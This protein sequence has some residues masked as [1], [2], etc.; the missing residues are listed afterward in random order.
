MNIELF[1]GR[2]H[3]LI[4]HLPIGFFLLAIIFEVIGIVRKDRD[5]WH[6]PVLV[7]L[8]VGIISGLFT[9]FTGL[10]LSS[11]GGYELDSLNKHKWLGISLLIVSVVL[12]YFKLKKKEYGR[13]AAI[14][15]I[16]LFFS[17]ISLTGHF[18]GVMTHGD[19]YLV[20]YAPEF[21]QRL[22]GLD[23][24]ASAGEQLSAPDSVIIYRDIVRPMFEQKCMQCHS[25]SKQSGKLDLSYHSQLLQPAESGPP[26]SA[27][28]YVESELFKRVSLS[29]QSKK[30]MPPKGTPLSYSELKILQYW[31]NQGADSAAS[32]EYDEMSE[33]LV[34]LMIRDYGLDFHP[35]PYY[36]KVTV[37]MLPDTAFSYLA[38]AGFKVK[39][40]SA[41]NY[42]LDVSFDGS[43]IDAAAIEKLSSI[44]DRITFLKMAE[45]DLTDDLV[46]GL[47][48]MPHLT[49]LDLHGNDISDEGINHLTKYRNLN[50]VNL[51]GTGLSDNGLGTLIDNTSLD[52]VYVWQSN[53]TDDAIKKWDSEQLDVIGGYSTK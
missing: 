10:S 2:L 40:L 12:L 50:V 35:R 11:E 7:S 25:A 30:F 47:A 28:S 19:T 8:V 24:S 43:Q 17:W 6:L 36:E 1:F 22:A 14:A 18:G 33:E 21:V 53:V 15:S 27:G 5:A 29:P 48:E 44:A 49:F 45:C 32:F 39:Y 41:E 46:V 9:V 42:L 16:I 13:N 34:Q 26:I 38:N 23:V 20:E 37:D 4:V 52:R 3:P 31:I 51:Y